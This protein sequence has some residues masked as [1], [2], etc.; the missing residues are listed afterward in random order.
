MA[1]DVRDSLVFPAFAACPACSGDVRGAMEADLSVFV[2]VRCGSSWHVE[3]GV[4]YRLEPEGG[5]E[6][7]PGVDVPPAGSSS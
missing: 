4:V 6:A 7:H 2:C 1:D 3:L 5:A